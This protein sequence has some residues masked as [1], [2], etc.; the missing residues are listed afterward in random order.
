MI[1]TAGKSQRQIARELGVSRTRVQQHIR[2][3]RTGSEA[4]HEAFLAAADTRY[5]KRYERAL[6]AKIRDDLLRLR[7]ARDELA[8]RRLDELAGLV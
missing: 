3:E 8:A 2:A 1:P 7:A 5:L 4:L 6:T